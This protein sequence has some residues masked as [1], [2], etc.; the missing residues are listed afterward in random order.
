MGQRGIFWG[1]MMTEVKDSSSNG[2]GG[3]EVCSTT[4]C[5]TDDFPSDSIFLLVEGKGG[6]GGREQL[7]F[8]GRVKGHALLSSEE[9]DVFEFKG[10]RFRG[11]DGIF[12]WPEEKKES[13]ADHI[14]KCNIECILGGKCDDHDATD[15][16]DGH[17]FDPVGGWVF[18]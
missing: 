17:W 6:K 11:A 5:V 14:C 3:A 9:L 16:W 8:Q 1:M 10:G 18:F 2:S 15:H 12:T 4:R 13:D 7:S